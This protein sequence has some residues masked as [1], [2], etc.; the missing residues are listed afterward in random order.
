[1]T[2]HA[3]SPQTLSCTTNSVTSPTWVVRHRRPI[4]H[5]LSALRVTDN[6][7]R[8]VSFC[9]VYR[10]RSRPGLTGDSTLVSRGGT[11]LLDSPVDL[12]LQGVGE[13]RLDRRQVFRRRYYC[14]HQPGPGLD[15]GPLS[16][17]VLTE[18]VTKSLGP[19]EGSVPSSGDLS[20]RGLEWPEVE[21]FR[22][23]F[24]CTLESFPCGSPQVS[25]TRG[26]ANRC[27]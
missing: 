7:A 15:G 24:R 4:P 16:L 3:L 17:V 23:R 8:T 11:H 19:W 9:P 6:R 25:G 22:D 14:L 5:D 12:G 20:T 21:D 1:M 10:G 13:F 27:Q 26:R 2:F 18:T